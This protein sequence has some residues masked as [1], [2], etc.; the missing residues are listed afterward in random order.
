MSID[1]L[2]ELAGKCEMAEAIAWRDMVTAPSDGYKKEFKLNIDVIDDNTY[3]TC[4]SIPFVHFN[5]V[6]GFGTH[7]KPADKSVQK[8]LD[9]VKKKDLQFFFVYVIAGLQQDAE[10]LLI[11][12]GFVHTG[13]WERIYRT[14]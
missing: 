2:P 13:S 4:P 8:I 6:L 11:R 7:G 3:I 9:Y 12:E 10:E 5:C 1:P 14:N